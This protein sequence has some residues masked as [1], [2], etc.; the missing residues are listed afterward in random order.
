M[1]IGNT[2]EAILPF[3][4]F[5]QAREIVRQE[6]SALERLAAR[7]PAGFA[8][9][10]SMICQ[11]RGCVIV[12][13]IGKAGWIAQ[14]VSATMASTGT[15]SHYL[16][17]AEAFHGD[18]GRIGPEDIVLV[19]SNSGETGEV[20]S[21]L[22]AIARHNVPLIS[23]VATTNNSLARASAVVLDYGRVQEA[24]PM[25][26]APSTSTTVMLAMGDALALVA[27]RVRGF[28]PA[29]FAKFHPGGSLG[30]KLSRVD[31]IM[32]PIGQCRVACQSETLREIYIRLSGPARRSGVILLVDES[33]ILAGIFTDSDLARLLERQRDRLLDGPVSDV[34]TRQPRTV[35]SGTSTCA[36]VELM[37]AHNLSELPVIDP[38]GTPIGLIDVTDVVGLVQ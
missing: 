26:L 33:G 30:K 22:P 25:G 34:M 17:P 9:A 6:A 4:V 8:E 16:H 31:D 19:L 29:D 3:D 15:R 13:G 35:K 38:K 20:L 23:I 28:Q 5:S 11:C 32:R 36:A 12:S 14:K 24:C 10:V 27:S 21:L 18:L 37:S 2:V 7:I 1:S